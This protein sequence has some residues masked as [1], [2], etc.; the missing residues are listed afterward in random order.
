MRLATQYG[1]PLGEANDI[2]TALKAFT[3]PEQE[4]L[5]HYWASHPETGGWL[6]AKI[7]DLRPGP[8]VWTGSTSPC[9]AD[10]GAQQ[11]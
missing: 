6:P 7:A 4:P 2:Y 11:R 9:A 8:T 5:L 10:L 3:T 1:V